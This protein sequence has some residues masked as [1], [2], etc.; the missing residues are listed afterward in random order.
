M[1][2]DLSDKLVGEQI[3]SHH[4]HDGRLLTWEDLMD[5]GAV[6][7]HFGGVLGCHLLGRSPVFEVT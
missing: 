1:N 4:F 5:G 3:E 7:S 6:R 2:E